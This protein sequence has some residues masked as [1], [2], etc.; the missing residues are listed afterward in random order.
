MKK[1]IF[2]SLFL[3]L[4][5]D[6]ANAL[7]QQ[8]EQTQGKKTPSLN[9][10]DAV[11]QLSIIAAGDNPHEA[12]VAIDALISFSKLRDSKLQ[13]LASNEIAKFKQRAVAALN[14]KCKEIKNDTEPEDLG[15]IIEATFWDVGLNAKDLLY[16]RAFDNIKGLAFVNVKGIRDKDLKMLDGLGLESLVIENVDIS[17][18]G[19]RNCSLPYL[20]ILYLTNSNVT[21]SGLKEIC[22]GKFPSL[23]NYHLDDTEITDNGLDWIPFKNNHQMFWLTGTD[24]SKAKVQAVKE[25]FKKK[26]KL[27][28]LHLKTGIGRSEKCTGQ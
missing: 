4:N 24:V 15:F 12:R 22:E 19:F 27:I 6:G 3:C 14:S 10:E 28:D 5:L 13:T 16:L 11:S 18:E 1:L 17:G 23:T 9:V 26:G 2:I 21:D 8:S 20:S 25:K 7:S